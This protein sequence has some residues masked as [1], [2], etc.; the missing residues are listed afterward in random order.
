MFV[1]QATAHEVDN[2]RAV[3][4][5]LVVGFVVFWRVALRMLLAILIIAAVVGAFVLLQSMHR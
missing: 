5:L 3:L 2:A 4:V 1:T